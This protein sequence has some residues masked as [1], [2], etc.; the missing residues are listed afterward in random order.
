[1]EVF[2]FDTGKL[3]YDEQMMA[4]FLCSCIKFN[5]IVFEFQINSLIICEN[6]EQKII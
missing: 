6:E 1:M 2:F 5:L 4:G 3:M